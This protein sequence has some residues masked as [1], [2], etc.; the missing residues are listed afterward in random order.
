[1]AR[2]TLFILVATTGAGKTTLSELLTERFRAIKRI[3]SC[4]TRTRRHGET[5]DAYHWLSR[6]DFE[7]QVRAGHFVEH[8]EFGGNLYGRRFSDFDQL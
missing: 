3:R 1:M 6:Q 8:D 4:T 7:S 2:H 5:I